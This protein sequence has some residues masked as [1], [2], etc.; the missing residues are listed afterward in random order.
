MTDATAGVHRGARERGG[1]AGGKA[2]G[3]MID[4]AGGGAGATV[5]WSPAGRGADGRRC[6]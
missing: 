1:V 6:D 5:R 2:A 4:A 3:D